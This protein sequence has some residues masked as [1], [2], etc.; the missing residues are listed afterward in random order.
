M[1]WID[2]F[3]RQRH[4]TPD[5]V[6]WRYDGNTE[7]H[8]VTLSFRQ[9]DRE[10]IREREKWAA[11]ICAARGWKYVVHTEATLP[12]KT[13]FANLSALKVFAPLSYRDASVVDAI[14]FIMEKQEVVPARKLVE[15]CAAQLTVVPSHVRPVIAHMLWHSMLITD[16]N[17]LIFHEFDFLPG[18]QIQQR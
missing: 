11:Q 10:N 4:Y 13:M 5:F 8:E 3:G 2:R 6:V 16:F 9:K 1:H 15:L 18:V 7:I 12:G 17:K 14:K